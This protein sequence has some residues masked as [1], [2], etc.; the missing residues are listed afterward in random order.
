M[1]LIFDLDGTLVNSLP[2]LTV[3]LNAALAEQNLPTYEISQVRKLIGN[4]SRELCRLAA[5]PFT[6]E[7]EFIDLLDARF[8]HH[9]AAH[10]QQGTTIYDGILPL[11]T[12]LPNSFHLSVLSNKPH[13]FTQEIVTTLFPP[14]T[15]QCILGQRDGIAKKP[16][17]SGIT[18]ILSHSNHP[19]PRA[20]LI[21]DSCVDI[22][23]ATN[24]HIPSVAVSW[25]YEDLAAIQKASPDHL[26]SNV[27]QL[28]T[29]IH[30]LNPPS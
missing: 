21:G 18:E 24:A 30:T 3:A 1:H 19:D 11:L 27:N 25:G 8:K 22:Q 13:A 28:S 2:G 29:W 6:S 16:D 14:Q 15:F 23:T 20:Y 4:G 10:W 5:A 12:S 26:F 7:S 17:P 9:Y